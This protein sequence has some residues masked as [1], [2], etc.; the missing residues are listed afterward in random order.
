MQNSWF[1]STAQAR[2]QGV[3]RICKLLLLM[4]CMVVTH[5]FADRSEQDHNRAERAVQAKQ[6]LPLHQVLQKLQAVYPGNV[7]EVELED[8]DGRW[9]YE[10]KLLQ[11]GGE[12]RKIKLDAQ[13]AE[14]LQ[15]K[16]KHPKK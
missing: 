9:V 10:V 15:S 7:L 4:G 12:L 5:A 11:S 16:I 2:T 13:T 14:V 8:D 6:I 3:Q 1:K